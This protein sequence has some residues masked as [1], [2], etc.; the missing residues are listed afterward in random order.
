MYVYTYI[1]IYIYIYIWGPRETARGE[2]ISRSARICCVER[3]R[4]ETRQHAAV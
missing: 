3:R 1:Y 4:R 2:E